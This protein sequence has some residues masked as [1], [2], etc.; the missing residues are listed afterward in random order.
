MEL[1]EVIFGQFTALTTGGRFESR[2]ETVIMWNSALGPSLHR[3]FIEWLNEFDVTAYPIYLA[4][5]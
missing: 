4:V 5:S 1:V 3:L 2:Y